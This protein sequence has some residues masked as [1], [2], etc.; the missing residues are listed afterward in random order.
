M[1]DHTLMLN[2]KY[3]FALQRMNNNE[4]EYPYNVVHENKYKTGER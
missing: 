2:Y 4:H 1:T 3:I